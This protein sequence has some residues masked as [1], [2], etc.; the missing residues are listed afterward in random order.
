[1]K[2]GSGNNGLDLKT[3]ANPVNK[4]FPDYDISHGV[5]LD[6][7]Y[8][9]SLFT[10]LYS[11][12]IFPII[13]ILFSLMMIATDGWA[14]DIDTPAEEDSRQV[15]ESEEAYRR[16]MELGEEST[17]S[18][19]I[20]RQ[21]P[22]ANTPPPEGIDRLPKES[23][24]HLRDQLKEVIMEN[25]EWEPE[26]AGK[27]YSYEPSEAAKNDPELQKMEEE[28]WA[29]LVAEYHER[30]A[31]VQASPGTQGSGDD[32]LAGG[33]SGQAGQKGGEGQTG[34]KQ[35][36]GGGSSSGQKSAS[37][38]EEG[39][40]T[41]G[42]SQSALDFLKG[43]MGGSGSEETT[44]STEPTEAPGADQQAQ[45]EQNSS[46]NA[47]QDADTQGNPGQEDP[48]EED[49]E[50]DPG[51]ADPSPSSEQQQSASEDKKESPTPPAGS[52]AISDLLKLGSPATEAEDSPQQTEN[53][54]PANTSANPPENASTRTTPESETS[55]EEPP[56]EETPAGVI[57]ITE[58][59]R[60]QGLEQNTGVVA[61]NTDDDL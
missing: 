35:G 41:A 32:D 9:L 20:L 3:P 8:P 34:G 18:D 50:E 14:Q 33:Q 19:D 15:D 6:S 4:G 25:G 46:E 57:A 37:S 58:L 16:R 48:G 1:M 56:A 27:D 2:P 24:R 36:S 5:I 26:D 53:Q 23:Q 40:S 45:G 55:A 7:K 51:K 59:Q 28:A 11:R 54:E 44:G 49:P 13:L 47:G 12:N 31:A 52:L 60:A 38:E 21:N 61:E 10:Y 22:A 29:D 43:M 39:P 30:E 17:R 42:T